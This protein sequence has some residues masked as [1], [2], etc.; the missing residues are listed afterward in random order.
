MKVYKDAEGKVVSIGEWELNIQPIK[1][2]K[3]LSQEQLVEMQLKNQDPNLVY[4]EKGGVI[5]KA[6]NPI[7]EGVTEH[8][9]EVITLD[10]GA[11]CVVGDHTKL[12]KYPKIEDQLDA[13]FWAMDSGVLPMAR[14][15][16]DPIKKVKGQFP[17]T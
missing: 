16:Y 2:K 12:R 4:D 9:E 15:F 7:P 14:G 17:K 1:R 13:L 10:C 6:N 8:E 11:R 5:T 3:P